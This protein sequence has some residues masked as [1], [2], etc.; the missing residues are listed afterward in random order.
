M[1]RGPIGGAAGAPLLLDAL[2]PSPV[3]NSQIIPPSRS[4]ILVLPSPSESFL[5]L[6]NISAKILPAFSCLW[7]LLDPVKVSGCHFEQL[8]HV[9]VPNPNGTCGSVVL[10][11]QA[12]LCT[13]QWDAPARVAFL[14]SL[15][16]LFLPFLASVWNVNLVK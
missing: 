4:F 15:K 16:M 1:E 2:S 5:F 7:W 13:G 6:L 8:C 3:M 9:F 11:A 10:L 14:S 12:R